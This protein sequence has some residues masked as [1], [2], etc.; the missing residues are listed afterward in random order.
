MDCALGPSFEMTCES[1]DESRESQRIKVF[2]G[3]KIATSHI[4]V[5]WPCIVRNISETGALIQ[6]TNAFII[7]DRFNLVVD[8][9]GMNV[10][11]EVMWR[12]GT[13]VGVQFREE[14][15][16]A[17]PAN[18]AQAN[19][20]SDPN[21]RPMR[22]VIAEDDPDDRYFFNEALNECNVP[23]EAHF[24]ED[25]EDLLRHLFAQDEYASRS[26][27]D[28]IVLD[29]NMPKVDGRKALSEIKSHKATRV[30]PVVVLTTSSN[31]DD[32]LNIYDLGASSY[33]TK[34]P[35]LNEFKG[36]VHELLTFWN[37]PAVRRPSLT[38]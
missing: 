28:L 24:S 6:S 26:Q 38:M 3:G 7:P 2:K 15:R 36:I 19:K 10:A 4:E 30:I 8:A 11:C 32:I 18:I 20:A 37:R 22:L 23:Y 1:A 29:L 16:R 9:D 27:P 33:I 14:P 31:D 21:Q 35:G 17:T 34:P 13:K 25:G 5:T 12:R